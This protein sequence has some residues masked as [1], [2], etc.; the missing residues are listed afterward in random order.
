MNFASPAEEDISANTDFSRGHV[1]NCPIDLSKDIEH[2]F[3][4]TSAE[5]VTAQ[6]ADDYDSIYEE[7]VMGP[8]RGRRTATRMTRNRYH[9]YVVRG[10]TIVSL[11]GGDQ[12][13]I[14]V[15][16]VTM[17]FMQESEK[18]SASVDS[19]G[20]GL[21]EIVGTSDVTVPLIVGDQRVGFSLQCKFIICHIS[22]KASVI[23]LLIKS[24]KPIIGSVLSH[25]FAIYI[26]HEPAN[27]TCQKRTYL[28]I[29]FCFFQLASRTF[30]MFLKSFF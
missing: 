18:R 9:P 12:H 16:A 6:A 25:F 13:Q 23:C 2:P 15:P 4:R 7:Y 10:S 21:P 19:F 24:T 3:W 17:S 28:R 1:R 11:Q 30:C 27:C 14:T 20:Y 26:S 8:R 22:L 29:S 5:D